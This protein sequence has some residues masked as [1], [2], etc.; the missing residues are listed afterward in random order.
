MPGIVSWL[1]LIA[2]ILSLIAFALL[3]VVALE[4]RDL[5]KQIKNEVMPVI[6]SAQQTVKTVQGT[7]EFVSSGLV[8]PLITS[9]SVTAGVAKTV[10]VLSSSVAR[11]LKRPNSSV[12][13]R[14]E[15]S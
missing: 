7:S 11:G 6:G 1:L 2:A 14:A 12:Q 8:K 9:V 10:Q 15:D 3:V 5:I 13:K 4:I